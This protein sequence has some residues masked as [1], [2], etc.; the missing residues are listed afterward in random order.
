MKRLIAI[1][2][3]LCLMLCGCTAQ[4]EKPHDETKLQI[5]CTSFPAYDFAREIAG[6]RAELTLLIK[7]GS[8]VHSYEPTPKDMIRIQESDLF[9]CNGGE[10]EQWAKTLIT[11]E[12]NT[13]YMMGCVDTVEE[14]A[15]GIYNAEDGEPELDEH[16]WT[17][18]LNAIKISEEICNALC[19]LDTDNAEAY[20]TNFTAYKAQLM[21]LDRKFRQVIKNSGK[22]TLVFADRFPMRY[23]A[24]EYG[25]DCYAAFPGCSS[26]TEP[27]AKTVAYLIDRVRED[28]IPAVLY[29]EFSN[30][31]MADVICEDTGCKKLP[32]YSAH[33]VSAEQFE[34]GVSYLDLMRI[35]LNSLKEALG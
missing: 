9:I 11:P 23:F 13:I 7:P 21:A 14:S 32:F 35:N 25:L 8:E 18:P 17:S 1:L 22:H 26:E 3:C 15:D 10:S 30:Q 20:K 19:K 27:S 34:Q 5:V 4:P 2:L 6:D 28:K 29:M 31:K 12:L 16:V 33:S 24:L